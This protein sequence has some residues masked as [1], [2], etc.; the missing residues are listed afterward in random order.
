MGS[1]FAASCVVRRI[2]GTKYGLETVHLGHWLEIS[3]GSWLGQE[4]AAVRHVGGPVSHV[5]GEE[6]TARADTTTNYSP[7]HGTG[8]ARVTSFGSHLKVHTSRDIVFSYR[9]FQACA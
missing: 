7:A 4:P 2:D 8:V 3:V 1:F 6:N 5:H 9:L